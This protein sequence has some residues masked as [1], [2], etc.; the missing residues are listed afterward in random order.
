MQGD[1]TVIMHLNA[2]LKNEMAIAMTILDSMPR[3]NHVIKIGAR[4][5]FGITWKATT[6]G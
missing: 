4:T 6:Y 5:T 1:E 2:V 3:P